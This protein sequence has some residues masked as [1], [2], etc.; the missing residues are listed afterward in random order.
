[1]AEG[2]KFQ[3][4]IDPRVMVKVG[5]PGDVSVVEIQDMLFTVSGNTA[6]AVL[7][8]WNVH[9]SIQGSSGL[10]G[11]LFLLFSIRPSVY[12]LRCKYV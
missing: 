5:Q 1:M 10:W 12:L 8:E 11:T 6:G 3:D 9:E 2:I 7:M 4:E